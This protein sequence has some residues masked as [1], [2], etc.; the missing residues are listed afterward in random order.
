LS[1]MM[2]SLG[3]RVRLG[4]ML[5]DGEGEGEYVLEQRQFKV[6]ID[7]DLAFSQ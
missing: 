7:S 4:V 2:S 5:I 6:I 3:I 1:G